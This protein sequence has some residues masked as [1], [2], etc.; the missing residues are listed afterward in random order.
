MA[1]KKFAE[2]KVGIFVISALLIVLL[3]I[4]WV[5][6]FSVSSTHKDLVVYFSSINALNEGDPV[7]VNGVKKGE[8]QKIELLGDSVRIL[9]NLDNEVKIKKDYK[10]EVTILE[11]MGGKQLYIQPGKLSQEVNYNE[12]L[13]GKQG[14]DIQNILSSVNDLTNDVKTISSQLQ[15]TIDNLNGV[16]SNVNGVVSDPVMKGN[17]KSILSNLDVT[18]RNLNLL[19]YENRGSFRN[20]TSHVDKTFVNIDSAVT[21]SSSQMKRTFSDLQL[22]TTKVDDLVSNLNLI[23]TD[24]Q[25]QRTGLGKFIYNDKFYN[26]INDALKEIQTLSKKIRKDGVKI[27][28]F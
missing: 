8:I 5:K 23:V 12:P 22:L 4:K 18:S 15:K 13:Y 24:V 25:S 3:T 21:G 20:L 16:I 17:L 7:N 27:D 11:L 2:F 6:D 10:A 9:F 1:N 19:V 26:N 14:G 28:L